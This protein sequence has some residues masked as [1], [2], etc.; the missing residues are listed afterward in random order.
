[1]DHE[2]RR[3]PLPAMAMEVRRQQL[4]SIS[5]VRQCK[6]CVMGCT[7]RLEED[8]CTQYCNQDVV[9]RGEE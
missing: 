5:A 4:P 6:V 8:G 1:M 2:L 9:P 7:Q 3:P